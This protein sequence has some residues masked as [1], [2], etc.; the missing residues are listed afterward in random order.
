MPSDI[1]IYQDQMVA[2]LRQIYPQ[3]IE[4]VAEWRS[5]TTIPNVY[6]PRL[7]I[8]VGPFSTVRGGNRIADYDDLMRESQSFIET[9]THYHSRNIT[10]FGEDRFSYPTDLPLFN[11]LMRHNQNARCFIAVEIENDVTRKHLL[12]GALNASALGRI[13]IAIGWSEKKVIA[14]V[15]LREYWNF[16]ASVNKNTF[17]TA[18]LLILSPTQFRSAIES[19]SAE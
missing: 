4:L 7:D 16:L 13:G 9:L 11:V 14:L 5:I 3:P 15:R 8:A 10:H 2:L 12:G 18:N 6:S 1:R 17:N 19:A